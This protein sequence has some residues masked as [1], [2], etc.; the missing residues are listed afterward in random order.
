MIQVTLTKE[1]QVVLHELKEDLTEIKQRLI[2][3]LITLGYWLGRSV[4]NQLLSYTEFSMTNI[5]ARG[6]RNVLMDRAFRFFKI[7]ISEG[8]D[9]TKRRTTKEKVRHYF[10]KTKDISFKKKQI[11]QIK[12][13]I[14][15]VIKVILFPIYLFIILIFKKKSKEKMKKNVIYKK[16]T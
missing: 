2:S 10:S 4:L 5:R 14:K 11:L 6:L 15:Q 7:E 1:E 16:K 3:G 8:E 12:R 9:V 13:A